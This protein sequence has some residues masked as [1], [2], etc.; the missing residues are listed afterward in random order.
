[1]ERVIKQGDLRPMASNP[2]AMDDLNNILTLPD[3][4]IGLGPDGIN[5]GDFIF[6]DFEIITRIEYEESILKELDKPQTSKPKFQGFAE[7]RSK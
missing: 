3:I 2:K 1:M 6:D 4:K 7:G 5:D